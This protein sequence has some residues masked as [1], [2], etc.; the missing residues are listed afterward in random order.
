MLLPTLRALGWGRA[1]IQCD[2]KFSCLGGGRA[3][4]QAQFPQGVY[5]ATFNNGSGLLPVWG[6][7]VCSRLHCCL[8]R[9]PELWGHPT[10]L[11]THQ[12]DL[13]T[14][15]CHLCVEGPTGLLE[16]L[17]LR[18]TR[19]CSSGHWAAAAGLC[20]ALRPQHDGPFARG[21]QVPLEQKSPSLHCSVASAAPEFART[22][23]IVKVMT[24]HIEAKVHRVVT[25]T[26]PE[27]SE[28]S[29][30]TKAKKSGD[31]PGCSR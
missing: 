22:N 25:L 29:G 8:P 10:P 1:A 17:S 21:L 12:R 6:A 27:S 9:G 31:G 13:L 30:K 3:A 2:I 24:T 28:S 11:S 18:P 16:I 20:S 7:S 15:P 5:A 23:D 14:D 4:S 26:R 19:I